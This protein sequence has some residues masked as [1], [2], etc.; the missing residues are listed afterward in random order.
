MKT[1]IF[2]L[3]KMIK[4]GKAPKR[5]KFGSCIYTYQEYIADYSDE[6][7]RCLFDGAIN[8]FMLNDEV[9]I[10]EEDNKIEKITYDEDTTFEWSFGEVYDKINELIDEVNKLKENK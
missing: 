6:D 3:L 2:K 5:I 9:E 7:D 10:I 8:T 4:D 1:T